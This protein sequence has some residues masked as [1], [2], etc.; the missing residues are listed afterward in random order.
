VLEKELGRGGMAI[1][2]LARDLKHE[3]LVALKV[4]HPELAATLGPERFLREVRT[5]A[6]LQHPHILPVHDSG[7]AAGQLWYTMP[8]VR[9]ESLR[10]RLRRE[11]QLPV[12]VAVDLG[13][14]VALALDYA[15]REGVVHRDLKPENIL[16]S[17]GQALL[18][19][20]G[21]ARALA[22]GS[23]TQLTETGMA[24]GTP[25]Y[26]SPEQATAGQMDGRSD[27]YALGCVLYEML[28]G[29]PPFTGPTPH[30][31]LAKR[32]LEPVPHVRTLRES[33]PEPLEQ[34][35]T[36]ALAKAPADRF[37]TAAEFARELGMSPMSSPATDGPAAMPA[38]AASA[39]TPV[40]GKP[41]RRRKVPTSLAAL[42]LAVLLGLVGLV[43]WLRTRPDA[44][45]TRPKR[46]AVLPFENLGGPEDEYFADGIS[47]E[48]RGKLAALPTLQ[49]TARSSSSQYK[50]TKKLPQQIGRELGADYLLTGTV[51]W[52]K[53]AGAQSRVRV[54]PE[55]IQAST[56][57]TKWQQPFDAVL[58]DVFQVQAEVSGRVA[59]ALDIALGAGERRVLEVKPTENLAAYDAYLRGNANYGAGA[60]GASIS[61]LRPATQWYE[62]AVTLD[63]LF[64]LAWARLSQAR[65]ASFYVGAGPAEANLPAARAAAE[66]SLRLMPDLPEAHVALGDYHGFAGRD[67]AR[68]MTEYARALVLAPKNAEILGRLANAERAQGRTEEALVHLRAAM[69]LDPRSELNT[70]STTLV[71]LY[72]R[73]YP[74]ALE[75]AERGIRLAPESPAGYHLK[76]FVYLAQ[77]DLNRA[78]SVVDAAARLIEPSTLVAY[79]S[80]YFDLYWALDSAQQVL[81]LRLTPAS[82]GDDTLAWGLAL[83]ATRALRGELKIARAYADSARLAAESILRA[84]PEYAQVHTLRGLALAYL[85]RRA[86]AVREGQRGLAI[87]PPSEDAYEGPYLQHQF[88]RIFMLL[89]DQERALAQLEPL[90]RMPYYLSPG[91]LKIDP[92]FT[93]LRGNPRFEELAAGQ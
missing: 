5:T 20:F 11:V 19:D 26:M 65:T 4:L 6:R 56:G 90:L 61:A 52:D 78:R 41:T 80:T 87:L 84:V 88:V 42:A 72:L 34:A 7:E 8:F 76:A 86:D 57:S 77:G 48:L 74:E 54:S 63:S 50:Q 59:Q 81:L 18:A 12:E 33:V 82:F 91:W 27:I 64:A 36:R 16:L 58:S 3:R 79:F 9:G 15:H 21:V 51:R 85:G 35:I 40:P 25:A 23:E 22:A 29:E 60:L 28:A 69:I 47:D 31:V 14:Q 32:V 55:L 45:A 67:W 70:S 53:G 2:Y 37:Q 24:L 68:A 43:I 75:S 49:V 44:E 17:E 10:D 73:R 39:S 66:R 83:A 93:P 46:V 71:L 62:R 89:G 30:A 13:R 1:V 38:S 92:T